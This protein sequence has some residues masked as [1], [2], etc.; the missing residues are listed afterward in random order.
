LLDFFAGVVS[1]DDER[2]LGGIV[3]GS[4]EKQ[5]GLAVKLGEEAVGGAVETRFGV[6]GERDG[7]IGVDAEG[8]RARSEAGRLRH[9]IERGSGLRDGEGSE[10]KS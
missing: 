8:A 1:V 5:A 3:R 10:H 7:E 2:G 9:E 4:R 6:A